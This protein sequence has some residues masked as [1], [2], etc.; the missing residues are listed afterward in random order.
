MIFQCIFWQMQN[1]SSS[2]FLQFNFSLFQ[3]QDFP[4]ATIQK[5]SLIGTFFLLSN[6]QGLSC[7]YV[8]ETKVSVY[9]V[10]FFLGLS[11]I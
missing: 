4:L 3:S 10:L 2:R 6:L 11:S 8:K 1:D 7:E 5:S 9:I